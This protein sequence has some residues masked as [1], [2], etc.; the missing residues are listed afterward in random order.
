MWWCVKD[1]G[2]VVVMSC[3]FEVSLSLSL[4]LNKVGICVS[5]GRS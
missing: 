3:F 1:T 4:A 2:Y 5:L